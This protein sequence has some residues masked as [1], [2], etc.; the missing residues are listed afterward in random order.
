[1]NIELE[2]I[3]NVN[4][5]PDTL[6]KKNRIGFS[7][8]MLVIVAAF[9]AFSVVTLN[10]KTDEATDTLNA[11]NAELKEV[12]ET[13]RDLQVQINEKISV[14]EAIKIATEEY[15]MVKAEQLPQMYVSVPSE[16]RGQVMEKPAEENV[17]RVLFSAIGESL[18]EILE[19]MQG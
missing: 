15:G 2:R 1:M 7:T 8:V 14:D 9:L 16:D 12:D 10:I 4:E 11:I 17:F 18:S 19:Y 13:Q 5:D 6:G 3:N